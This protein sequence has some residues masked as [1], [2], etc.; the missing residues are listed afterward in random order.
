MWCRVLPDANLERE[1]TSITTTTNPH[2]IIMQL[3]EAV[4][5]HFNYATPT[6]A[7][8]EDCLPE[9][10][11]PKRRKAVTAYAGVMAHLKR[12]QR[13]VIERDA[14]N[15]ANSTGPR[16]LSFTPQTTPVSRNPTAELKFKD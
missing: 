6:V 4:K 5:F 15:S 3:R 16:A 13:N 12:G 10:K 1:N 7:A 9:A 11:K 2:I 8:A 14:P